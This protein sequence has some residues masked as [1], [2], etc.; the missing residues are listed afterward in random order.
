MKQ[1]KSGRTSAARAEAQ[2]RRDSAKRSLA[3]FVAAVGPCVMAPGAVF[4][5]IP[6]P[7]QEDTPAQD[8]SAP[9]A[10]DVD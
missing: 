9:V 3:G 6:R 1:P 5:Q 8:A 10:P 2:K 7:G 4:F